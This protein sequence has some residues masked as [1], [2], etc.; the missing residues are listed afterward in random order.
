[1]YVQ[2]T[3]VPRT[4]YLRNVRCIRAAYGAAAKSISVISQGD[5]LWLDD[6][7]CHSS[8]DQMSNSSWGFLIGFLESWSICPTHTPHRLSRPRRLVLSPNCVRC[9]QAVHTQLRTMS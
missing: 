5:Q 2:G 3:S 8:V 7:I 4:S 9:T 1:M 6:R